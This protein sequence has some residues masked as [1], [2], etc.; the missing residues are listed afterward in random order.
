MEFINNY[1][2]STWQ[3]KT[4]QGLPYNRGTYEPSAKGGWAVYDGAVNY[5]G[6]I[7]NDGRIICNGEEGDYKMSFLRAAKEAL[8]L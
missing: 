4:P 3:Q 8:G 5:M 2:K 6:K 1:Y 7:A